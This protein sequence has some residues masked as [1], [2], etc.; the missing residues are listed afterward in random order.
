MNSLTKKNKIKQKL[1]KHINRIK[2]HRFD[3]D[4]SLATHKLSAP[5]KINE[6]LT[7]YQVK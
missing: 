2:H 5:R 3:D 7:I 6:S 4:K 1:E